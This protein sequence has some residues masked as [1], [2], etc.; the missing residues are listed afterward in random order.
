M[1]E[2]QKVEEVGSVWVIKLTGVLLRVLPHCLLVLLSYPVSFFYYLFAP[3]ARRSLK[4][5]IRNYRRVTG[6]RLFTYPF[7]LAFSMTL[8][9]K[10]ESWAGKLSAKKSV[11]S[12]DGVADFQRTLSEGKGAVM[13]FSHLGSSEEMRALSSE[14]EK[15]TLGK[16][17][18]LVSV[19]DFK[20]AD[21]FNT[22]LKTL[23]PNVSLNL[24]SIHDMDVSSI[25][26]MSEAIAKGGLVAIAGDRSASRNI[27][28]SFLG[29]DACF[30]YGAFY[31]PALLD[32]P[33]YFLHCVR[34]KTFGFK[35]RYV[36][37]I[38]KCSAKLEGGTRKARKAYAE[39]IAEEYALNL[40]N[41]CRRYPYQWYN[42]FDFWSHG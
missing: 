25:D 34:K 16:E 26:A 36:V 42:F 22:M 6:K 19:V 27:T 23:N 28:L 8:V 14:F 24:M 10:G 3:K 29:E 35:R 38:K 21:K 4:S 30:P 9:E 33:V 12:G 5:Y 13:I 15:E 37:D 17:L 7:F 41:M 11:F 32:A 39:R 40:E 20:V 1:R 31:I 18:P 2:W